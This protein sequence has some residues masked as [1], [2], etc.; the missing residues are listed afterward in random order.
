MGRQQE[1]MAMEGHGPT[2]GLGDARRAF[3]EADAA[4]K[5]CWGANPQHHLFLLECP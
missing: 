3:G 4:P 1:G 2:E 5:P